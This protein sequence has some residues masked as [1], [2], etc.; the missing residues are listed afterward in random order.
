MTTSNKNNVIY[1]QCPDGIDT[2]DDEKSC[3]VNHSGK[4]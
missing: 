1:F 4:N 2:C 3:K